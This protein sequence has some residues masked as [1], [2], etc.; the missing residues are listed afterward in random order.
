MAARRGRDPSA[1]A[2][3]AEPGSRL[4]SKSPRPL[5]LTVAVALLLLVALF[6]AAADLLVAAFPSL[7]SPCDRDS[8]RH[9]S[10]AVARR[11]LP[12]V[13]NHLLH[14]TARAIS[15]AQNQTGQTIRNVLQLQ[16]SSTPSTASGNFG[17]W[18]GASS[19]HSNR[20]GRGTGSGGAKFHPGGRTYSGYTVRRFLHMLLSSTH[21]SLSRVRA[22]PSHKPKQPLSTISASRLVTTLR[23]PLLAFVPLPEVRTRRA[24]APVSP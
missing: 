3:R 15:I 12:K 10:E 6:V 18:N 5:F 7:L 23:R 16:S 19:S 17:A 20:N 24:R 2:A 1:Q 13:A 22:G 8:L 9:L 11:M 21:I 14:H 4:P